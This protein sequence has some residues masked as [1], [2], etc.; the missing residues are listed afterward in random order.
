[1]ANEPAMI[2]GDVEA[3]HQMRVA[4]RRLQAAISAFSTIVADS[5]W[6][7]IRSELRWITGALGPVRD[8]D[9]FVAEV[10][11]PLRS[12]NPDESGVLS[13]FHD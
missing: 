13:I 1:M 10:L 12:Q 2:G 3:L 6:Q 7:K 11:I 8:L 4:L 5:D 9:V